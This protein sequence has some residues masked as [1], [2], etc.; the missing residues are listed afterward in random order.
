MLAL[1]GYH[2]IIVVRRAAT[3]AA[4][5]DTGRHSTARCE[6]ELRFLNGR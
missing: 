1:K 6:F 2:A 4:N 5:G 3:P